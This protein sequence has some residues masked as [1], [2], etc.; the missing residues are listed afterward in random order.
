MIPFLATTDKLRVTTSSG[1]A[2]HMLA[3]YVKAPTATLVPNDAAYVG[4]SVSSATDTD[5]FTGPGSSECRNLKHLTVRNT[6]ASLSVDITVKYNANGTLYELHK[7]TL[8]PGECLEYLDPM[9]FVSLKPAAVL[10]KLIVMASDSVHAT[11]ATFADIAG[12]TYPLK[13]G[14]R[15]AVDACLFSVNNASTT[16]SQFGYNIGAAPTAALLGEIGAVTNSVT[17]GAF[18]TGTATARDTAIVAQTTGQ[19]ATGIHLIGGFIQPSAD[20]T[21][22]MRAT[23]EVTVAAGLTV[24]AGSWLWIRQEG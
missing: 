16:G 18:G 6:D 17:A 1:A 24:K 14:I 4:A 12:L 22:A 9:G 19:T 13:S 8:Q 23:S 20:G 5:L 7:V 15:Y 10:D 11:A 2:V 21:F 3:T